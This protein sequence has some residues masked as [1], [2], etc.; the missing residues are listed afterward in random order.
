LHE[1]DDGLELIVQLDRDAASADGLSI[2]TP[3]RDYERR[4]RV[5]GSKDG[6]EWTPL[7]A[8]GLVF[9]YSRYIDLSNCEIRL[10][11]NDFRQLKILLS[12]IA[13]AKESPFLELTR[14]YRGGRDAETIEKTVLQRRPF[15]MDRIELWREI[16]ETIAEYEK[17][18]DYPVEE[19]RTEED[20]A[21]KNTI[22]EIE[23]QREPL[24]EFTIETAS[25][26]FSRSIAIQRAAR[27]GVRTEWVDIARGKMSLVDFGGYRKQGLTIDF[28]E[29]RETA[30]R[31]VIR[32][33]D[34][35][36][37]A[38]TGVK[39]RG[40]VYRA[41]FLAA[42]DEGYRLAYGAEET[43]PPKYDTA[44]VLAPLVQ[45]HAVVEAR[46]GDEIAGPAAG[47][48]PAMG[49][50]SALNNPILL[51]TVIVLLVAALGWALFQAAKRIDKLPREP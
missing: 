41:V 40:N 18:A 43:D 5:L 7:A 10:P 31:I 44:T 27:R 48:P 2:L 23:T 42:K 49:L 16:P 34:N 11:K 45:G 30:Y 37:L 46:L 28:P 8:G 33:E 12:G 35:P 17:K 3:L 22:V 25:R 6:A 19:F 13:D 32:N 50:R 1:Q 26:N 29:Q 9:D 15:R 21:D 51:G 14:K 36:P 4:V 39:A 38:I 24:T 47:S 20:P